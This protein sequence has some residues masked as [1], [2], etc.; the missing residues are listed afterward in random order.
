MLA[1]ILTNLFRVILF[2]DRFDELN[3]MMER[4]QDGERLFGTN[5]T[6]FPTINENKRIFNLLKKLYDLYITVNRS[7]ET[8]LNTLYT[9]IRVDEINE[10]LLD[11]GNKCRKL[12]KSLKDWPTFLDL[13]N[14]IDEW[15][16][17]MLIVELM[18]KNSLKERHWAMIENATN[19][20]L[21]VEDNDFALKDIMAAP[22]LENKDELEDICQTAIKEID[23]EAKLRQ[24]ILDW[25]TIKIELAQFKNRGMLLVKGQELGE[26]VAL[27]EDSQ[28]IMSSLASNR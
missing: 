19:T 15:T 28:M 1:L 24:I 18:V 14:K 27:L 13:K 11:Y 20:R 7:I 26:V 6:E 9:R 10:T 12:P 23:I 2:Q 4:Y 25:S 22:L 21:P 5:I 16:E 3:V 17:K 8:W